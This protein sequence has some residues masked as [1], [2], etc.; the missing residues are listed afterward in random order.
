MNNPFMRNPLLQ[1]SLFSLLTLGFL[2]GCSVSSRNQSE[3]PEKTISFETRKQ[4]LTTLSAFEAQGKMGYSDG[5]RGGNA[6]VR[7][8]Q[9][10][11]TYAIYLSGPLGSGATLIQGSGNKVSLTRS[12]GE[13]IQA[14]TPEALVK[15]ELGFVI[16]VSGLRFWLRGV[17]APGTAPTQ[18]RFDAQ[19]RLSELTQHGW[20]VIY[21]GYS[22]QNGI[23]MPE[24][25]FLRNGRLTLKFV[26]NDWRI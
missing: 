25:L 20:T 10:N 12:N 14:S 13:V 23:S 7:W 6:T 22:N 9:R 2:S 21:Q 1:L 3:L 4:K 17:P 11:D 15:Q 8:E 16:P 26:F 19:N 24:R 5:E 18:T